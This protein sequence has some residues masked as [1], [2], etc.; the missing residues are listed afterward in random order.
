MHTQDKSVRSICSQSL[1]TDIL[2]EMRQFKLL[3]TTEIIFRFKQITT[4]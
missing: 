3:P 4:N 2:V 1:E